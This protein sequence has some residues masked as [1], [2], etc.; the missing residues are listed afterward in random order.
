MSKMI[1]KTIYLEPHR[2]EWLE[3][4]SKE[5]GISQFALVRH[6]IDEMARKEAWEELKH[7]MLERT[8]IKVPQIGRTW[9]RDEL[10]EERL[11]RF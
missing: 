3:R 4:R 6:C 7:S 2:A 11:N 10:Y 5:L 8:K 9:T 1:R